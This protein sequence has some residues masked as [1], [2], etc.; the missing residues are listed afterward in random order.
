M[1]EIST[2]LRNAYRTL[3][4]PLIV[5]GIIIPIFDTIVPNS[6]TIP[7]F[8]GGKAYVLITDQN[9][10]ETTNTRCNFKKEASITFDIV[11]KFPVGSGGNTASELISNTIQE[12][13]KSINVSVI[14]MGTEFQVLNTKL[15]FSRNLIDQG[16]TL[17]AFRKIVTFTNTVYQLE[18]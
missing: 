17:T 9:E 11:V 1:K 10:V 7:T 14:N 4:N 6:A 8:K 5:D 12:A 15:E 13:V 16:Q 18:N 2:I 3:L